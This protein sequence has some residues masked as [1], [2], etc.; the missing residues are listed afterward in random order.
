[1]AFDQKENPF[2]HP[3][4]YLLSLSQKLGEETTLKMLNDL[5]CSPTLDLNVLS[6]D[7]TPLLKSISRKSYKFAEAL[8]NDDRCDVNLLNTKGDTPLLLAISQGAVSTVQSLIKANALVD[9]PNMSGKT[10][11]YAAV[12]KNDKQI[13][14]L[15]LDAGAL[16]NQWYFEGSLPIHIAKPDIAELLVKYGAKKTLPAFRKSE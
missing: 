13:V 12:E 4:H 11:L 6:D 7:D 10:P 15:L 9:M 2:P 16:P 1:M 3:L 14:Q 8:I 5:L